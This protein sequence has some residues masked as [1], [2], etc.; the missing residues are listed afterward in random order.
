MKNRNMRNHIQQSDNYLYLSTL[1]TRH[2]KRL[3]SHQ[4]D[5]ILSF[6]LYVNS[7]GGPHASAM[8]KCVVLF[9]AFTA[10]W[11]RVQE[12]YLT[13]TSK[14]EL[15]F[16]EETY[17]YLRPSLDSIV[18]KLEYAKVILPLRSI[19][20]GEFF[21]EYIK[22]GIFTPSEFFLIICFWLCWCLERHS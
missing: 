19:L 22:I 12:I 13:V 10:S 5:H 2:R 8:S 6:I 9:L 15:V 3:H 4:Y 14:A 21:T 20:E 18:H 7:G 11:M 1:N 17:N 16:S